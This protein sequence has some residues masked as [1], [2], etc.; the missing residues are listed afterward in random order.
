MI[1]IIKGASQYRLTTKIYQELVRL[2]KYKIEK[3]LVRKKCS[4]ECRLKPSSPFLKE[5]ADK[6]T[7]ILLNGISTLDHNSLI[8]QLALLFN[9]SI[10]LNMAQESQS[11]AFY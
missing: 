5:V 8:H 6:Y 4:T 1:A 11:S 7:E 2:L 9:S 10:Y 3:R